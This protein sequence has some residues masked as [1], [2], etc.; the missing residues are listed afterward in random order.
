MASKVSISNDA[1][2]RIGADTIISMTEDCEQARVCNQVFDDAYDALLQAHNWNFATE[3]AILSQQATGPLFGYS[4]KY[5]LPTN[6]YCLKVL[7]LDGDDEYKVEGR[8][9]LTDADSVSISYI[10]RVSDLNKLS[11]LFRQTLSLYIAS[12]VCYTLTGSATLKGSLTAEW[13]EIY[14]VARFEDAK[15][16]T[17]EQFEPGTW[18]TIRYGRSAA[19]R[20]KVGPR[21]Y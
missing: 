7:E 13:K 1:L 4:Y 8:Y 21:G 12:Q 6:P 18:K 17:P 19:R 2:I 3:R 16:G 10:S 14:R 11:P 5:L 20:N 9:L 15:E